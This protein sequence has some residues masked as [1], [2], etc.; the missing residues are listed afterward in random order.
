MRVSG[1]KKRKQREKRRAR[2]EPRGP[3]EYECCSCK[4]L[5]RGPLKGP[6]L[7]CRYCGHTYVRWINYDSLAEARSW[8]LPKKHLQRTTGK[9]TS[10]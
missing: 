9:A 10:A 2:T 8:P 7:A 1:N 4:G 5:W 6:E 3:G